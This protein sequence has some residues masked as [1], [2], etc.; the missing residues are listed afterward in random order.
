MKWEEELRKKI[1]KQDGPANK[2]HGFSFR[3]T[4][5]YDDLEIDEHQTA[6][7]EWEFS[8]GQRIEN[9][10]EIGI[11]VTGVIIDDVELSQSDIDYINRDLPEVRG[12]V[13]PSELI[14]YKDGEYELIWS[15]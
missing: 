1:I 10:R 15:Y 14:K 6:I 8:F 4:V 2:M 12:K 3:T 9:M 7:I 13:G 11:Y 5:D